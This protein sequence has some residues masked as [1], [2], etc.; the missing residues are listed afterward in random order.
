[1]PLHDCSRA[2]DFCT[3]R[4][5]FE[6]TI[7][8]S[9]RSRSGARVFRAITQYQFCQGDR[10]YIS[11]SAIKGHELHRS[12]LDFIAFDKEDDRR[13]QQQRQ[14]EE[15]KNIDDSDNNDDEQPHREADTVVGT[16]TVIEGG[17]IYPSHKKEGSARSGKRQRSS[18]PSSFPILKPAWHHS[19]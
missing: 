8:R 16:L 9:G 7:S 6:A 19:H 17:R 3:G 15:E 1:M 13:R 5:R 2:N 11:Q 14:R 4:V 10:L 18:L 12:V